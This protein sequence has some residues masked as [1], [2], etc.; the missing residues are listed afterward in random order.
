MPE[1]ERLTHLTKDDA[2]VRAGAALAHAT[3]EWAMIQH[4]MVEELGH[5]RFQELI[6]RADTD[7]PVGD[8]P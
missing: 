6:K 2:L 3:L 7:D 8:T 4:V 5:E 1:H